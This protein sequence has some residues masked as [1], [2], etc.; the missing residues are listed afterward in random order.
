MKNFGYTLIELMVGVSI[1]AIFSVV[2]L[3]QFR[4]FGED[5]ILTSAANDVQSFIR[6]AQ[7]NASTGVLC[8]GNGGASWSVV[9]NTNQINMDHLCSYGDPPVTFT[10]PNNL[11]LPPNIIINS[12][13]SPFCQSVYPQMGG[14]LT[15]IYAPITGGVTFETQEQCIKDG[16]NL[17]ITLVN[18]KTSTSKDVIIDKGGAVDVK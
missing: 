11:K 18:T 1:L 16:V 4:T 14:A 15:L 5:K 12:M 10:P 9:I 3:L 13:V 7:T 2:A 6:T 17:T 8:T